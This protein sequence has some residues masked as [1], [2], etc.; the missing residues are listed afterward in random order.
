MKKT[1][2]YVKHRISFPPEVFEY[3]EARATNAAK[4]TGAS[5][6]ISGTVSTIIAERKQQD[7]KSKKKN[8]RHQ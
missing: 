8:G 7:E 2:P 6:N 4:L 3:V 5:P 1:P